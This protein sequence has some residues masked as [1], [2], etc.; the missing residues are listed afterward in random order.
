MRVAHNLAMDHFR[1]SARHVHVALDEERAG[2]LE[3]PAEDGEWEQRAQFLEQALGQL[4]SDQREVVELRRQ[5]VP[6]KEIA[7]VQKCSLNTVLGRMHYAVQKIQRLARGA[8]ADE[9][10]GLNNEMS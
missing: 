1:K 10:A 9:M 7:L 5:G 8:G 4:S 6:F 3:A 2:E